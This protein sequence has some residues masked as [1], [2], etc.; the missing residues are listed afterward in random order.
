MCIKLRKAREIVLANEAVYLL[1]SRAAEFCGRKELKGEQILSEQ[2]LAEI[3]E[4]VEKIQ[5]LS[6]VIDREE[7]KELLEAIERKKMIARNRPKV[8]AET[9]NAEEL[10]YS[11]GI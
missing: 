3:V 9:P 4:R 8:V 11:Y 6:G 5:P 2:K 7:L 10:Q 1:K